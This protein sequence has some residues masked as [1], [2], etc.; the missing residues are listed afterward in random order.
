MRDETWKIHQ[1]RVTLTGLGPESSLCERVG[2]DAAAADTL[3]QTFSSRS[4]RLAGG[5]ASLSL[6]LP[7]ADSSSGLLITEEHVDG[8]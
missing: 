7:L 3:R 2:A 8:V 4:I 6:E 5:F 1:R